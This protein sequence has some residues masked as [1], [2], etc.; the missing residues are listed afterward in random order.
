MKN[1]LLAVI[2]AAGQG[3]RLGSLGHNVPKCLLKI[4]KTTILEHT[5]ETLLRLH[6][7]DI[8]LVIGT[9]GTCW[10]QESYETIKRIQNKNHTQLILNYDN[11][12]TQSLYSLYLSLKDTTKSSL[13]VTDGDLFFSES[14]AN[15]VL[16]DHHA[17]LIVSRRTN[18]Q[19]ASGTR[20]ATD[21]SGRVI[22]LENGTNVPLCF[23]YSGMAKVDERYF[24]EFRQ[25]LSKKEYSNLPI[26]YALDEFSQKYPLYNLELNEGW[27]N[28]NTF[29]D[30]ETARRMR[31]K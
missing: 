28:I 30:L 19:S 1:S 17:S 31:L 7:K 21:Q 12:I 27:I 8:S 9:K 25:I 13:L 16:N 24:T 2:L 20:V 3:I 5:I 10:T 23:I 26:N 11:E 6:I 18:D 14:V 15:V 29:Q 22:N 4:G